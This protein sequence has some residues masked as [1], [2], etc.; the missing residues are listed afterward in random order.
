[1]SEFMW[2]NEPSAI[3][4]GAYALAG[5]FRCVAYL[6]AGI[7]V[8]IAAALALNDGSVSPVERVLVFTVFAGG[9][10]LIAALL[11]FLGYVLALLAGIQGRLLRAPEAV[12]DRV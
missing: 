3:E 1:M 12:G 4:R 7:A 2:S 6:C 9:G 8:F 10:M 11:L 5:A